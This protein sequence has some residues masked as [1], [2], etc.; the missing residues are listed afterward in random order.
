MAGV[1]YVS[2]GLLIVLVFLIHGILLGQVPPEKPDLFSTERLPGNG[3]PQPFPPTFRKEQTEKQQEPRTKQSADFRKLQLDLE[4]HIVF[5]KSFAE[6][7]TE[8]GELRK[9]Q[10]ERLFA[11][12]LEVK[13]WRDHVISGQSSTDLGLDQL[14]EASK[15][16]TC[17][18]MD[19]PD[20]K[21]LIEKCLQLVVSVSTYYDN[22][23][24]ARYK[25][26]SYSITTA[27]AA[28]YHRRTAEIELLKFKRDNPSNK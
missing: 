19:F 10:R 8:D 17:S 11:A 9:L 3:I 22:I 20:S 23:A 24:Q 27:T 7:N 16:L 14:S 4:S 2:K 21:E 6:P 25:A 12:V 18:A 1:N 26:N 5:A 28:R 15:H 13:A